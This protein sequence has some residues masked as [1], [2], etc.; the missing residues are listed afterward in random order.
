[1][2]R[3]RRWTLGWWGSWRTAE[4]SMTRT[5]SRAPSVRPWEAR[6]KGDPST[7][8]STRPEASR[9]A[10]PSFTLWRSTLS[11][12]ATTRPATITVMMALDSGATTLRFN[13]PKT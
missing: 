13:E 3:L 4:P 7:D 12:A 8:T 6:T 11:T 10:V 5:W 1:A 9:R 2:E